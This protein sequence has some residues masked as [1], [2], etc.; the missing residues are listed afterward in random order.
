MAE[1]LLR[2]HLEAAGADVIVASAGLLPGGRPATDHGQASMARRGLDL[3]DH[4]SRRLELGLVAQA[5]LIIGMAREHVREVAVIDR[6]ALS[7]AFTLKELVRDATAVGPRSEGEAL[8]DWLQRVAVGR[9]PS[10][11]LGV[12]HDDAYDVADPVGRDR[13]DYEATAEELDHLLARL[14]DMAWPTRVDRR[15]EQ[16]R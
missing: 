9:R 3:T 8:A 4:V 12:G 10:T 14:V 16:L 15:A 7:R 6:E 13:A 2:K 1:V 11:L 5:D